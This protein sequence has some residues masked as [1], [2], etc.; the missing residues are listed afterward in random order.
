MFL[1]S[2]LAICAA[3]NIHGS[4][5]VVQVDRPAPDCMGSACKTEGVPRRFTVHLFAPL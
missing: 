1:M 3:G 4:K 2:Y 5:T